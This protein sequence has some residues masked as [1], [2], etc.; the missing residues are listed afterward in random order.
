MNKKLPKLY[1]N[2]IDKVIN[3]ND[4]VFYSAKE[5]KTKEEK[6]TSSTLKNDTQSIDEKIKALFNSPNFV[7]KKNATITLK[8]KTVIN[9]DIIDQNDGKLITIDD[10]TINITDIKDMKF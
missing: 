7:Y 9:K 10:E 1:V 4:L 3:N 8:D 6:T 2:K 5:L